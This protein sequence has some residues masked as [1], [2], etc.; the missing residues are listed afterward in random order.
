MSKRILLDGTP[1]FRNR[2]GVG[3]Y[4]Y[5]LLNELFKIDSTNTYKI[6]GFLFAGKKFAAPY[7]NLQQNVSYRLIRYL[8]SKVHNVVS[9]RLAV[10]PVDL[11]TAYK[12]DVAIYTNFVRAPL[13]FGGKTITFVYDISFV[14][15]RQFS[16]EKNSRL[17]N[18]Q[19]PITVKKSDIIVTISENAKKEIVKYYGVDARK[20]RIVYPAVDHDVFKKRNSV[21][22]D[23]VRKKFNLA[24]KYILYTGTIEPR[25][26]I[27]GI[28][29]GYCALT[30][31]I[32]DEY[33][34]VL[35]GGK[36][37]KD[38]E[39]NRSLELAKNENILLTGY[40]DDG[41]LPGLYSGAALFVYPSFYEGFGMPPLEAMAC[42]VPVITSDNSSLPEVV[43]DAGITISAEDTEALTLNM[44]KVLTNKEL[45]AKMRKAGLIQ[46]K[47]FSWK[48]SAAEMQKIISE[49]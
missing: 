20:I 42:G 32:R 12:P 25:K 14:T 38:T 1:I 46:A 43:G 15:H 36:G 21:E 9:R 6:Y 39:I 11:L 49:I 47:K 3:Q 34:L 24:K 45:A 30:K 33:Q 2:S 26:N 10:P 8:P 44:Q 13:V 35:A 17:L 18:S 29:D 28:V 22:V 7:K 16:N 41:D 37:W 4:V 23:T 31:K 5:R 40:V 27:V 19:V 48:S